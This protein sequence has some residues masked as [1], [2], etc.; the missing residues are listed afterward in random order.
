MAPGLC[1]VG[2]WPSGHHRSAGYQRRFKP[3]FLPVSTPT[4]SPLAL[5][6]LHSFILGL[7]LRFPAQQEWVA[8]VVPPTPTFLMQFCFW[9]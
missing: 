6:H 1:V 3:V 9:V 7:Q 8:L 5:T 4:P 2:S